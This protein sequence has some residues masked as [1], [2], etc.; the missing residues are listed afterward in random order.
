MCR[1]A[2][3]L[4]A[5]SILI[6]SPAYPQFFQST[7]FKEGAGLPSSESYMVFQDSKGFMWIATDNGVVKYDGHEFVT[8]NT[9]D[10]LTDNTVFGF[11]EDYKGRIWFRTAR[12]RAS[13]EAAALWTT[14]SL[15]AAIVEEEG[16]ARPI[17]S[18]ADD[19]VLAVNMPPHEP[20]PG[21]A[22]RSIS[23]RSSRRESLKS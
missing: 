15:S 8:Y 12:A 14:S 17:A 16:S 19:I 11:F 9:A 22:R 7:N 18:I 23:T 2:K 21:H 20:M 3:L 13:A 1:I 4:F 5:L 10:G 6:S